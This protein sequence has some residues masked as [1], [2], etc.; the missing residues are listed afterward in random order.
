[1]VVSGKIRE[2]IMTC[3]F[4][5]YCCPFVCVRGEGWGWGCPRPLVDF[6][7]KGTVMWIFQDS[8]C[9]HFWTWCSGDVHVI[10][11]YW[12][13]GGRL[14]IKMS[15]CQYRDPHVKDKTVSLTWEFHTWERWSLSWDRALSVV[16][17]IITV[18][19]PRNTL[20]HPI[21]SALRRY[22]GWLLV[23][24]TPCLY[25]WRSVYDILWYTAIYRECIK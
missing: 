18:S 7:Y 21:A 5:P 11:M 4:F 1:M 14:N 17:S 6:P 23:W 2:H 16:E 25:C 24:Q 9:I 10:V 8:V 22:M 20:K 3:K 15:S 19:F 12:K 13:A